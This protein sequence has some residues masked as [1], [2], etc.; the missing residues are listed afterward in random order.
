MIPIWGAEQLVG[1]WV[2]ARIEGCER[3]FGEPGYKFKALAVSDGKDLVAGMVY[4]NWHPEA[5]VIEISGAAS[6]ARWLTRPVLWAMFSYPFDGIGAQMVVMNVSPENE[7]FNGRGLKRLLKAYGFKEH[8]IP[9]L[10]GREKDG[11]LFT[12]TDDDWRANGFHKEHGV[13]KA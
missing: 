7:M 9:R 6:T 5:G 2:A 3:G 8:L 4:H 11:I 12:L 13:G 1:P 10:K